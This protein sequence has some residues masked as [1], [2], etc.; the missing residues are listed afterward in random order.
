MAK[1][2]G[3][4]RLVSRVDAN[5]YDANEAEFNGALATGKYEVDKCYMSPSGAYVLYEKDHAYHVEEMEAAKALADAGIIVELG[6]EG[7]PS[8]ATATDAYGNSK[9]S[10]GT[11]SIE[12]LTFE[13]STRTKPAKDAERA[14][15]KALEHCKEKGSDVAVIYDKAGAFHKA[16][17]AKGI[18]KYESFRTNTHRFKAILVIDSK[19]QVHEWKHDK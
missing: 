5:D 4:T 18:T 1:N 12:K 19:G 15:K 13:Q 6:K 9:F 8:L 10:E 16:D 11:L 17:I 3:G 2:E 7:D 14:V